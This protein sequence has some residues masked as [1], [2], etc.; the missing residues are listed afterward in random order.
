[1]PLE[2]ARNISTTQPNHRVTNTGC[3]LD[4]T[5]TRGCL[6]LVSRMWEREHSSPLCKSRERE[7]LKAGF[8]QCGINEALSMWH[9]NHWNDYFKKSRVQTTVAWVKINW[10][11]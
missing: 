6:T 4:F 2:V 10:E 7:I 3:K 11:N 8:I 5:L 9:M 1:M